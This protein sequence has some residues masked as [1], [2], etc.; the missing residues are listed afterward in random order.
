LPGLSSLSC[1]TAIE[2][3]AAAKVIYFMSM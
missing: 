1:E 2:R 3:F